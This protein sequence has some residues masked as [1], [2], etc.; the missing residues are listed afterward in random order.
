MVERGYIDV[1]AKLNLNSVA[2]ERG[3]KESYVITYGKI[4]KYFLRIVGWASF[5]PPLILSS[6]I[7]LGDVGIFR[8][9]SLSGEFTMHCRL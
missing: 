3:E 1:V 6:R 4:E 2:V 5:R 7:Y 9:H 8:F